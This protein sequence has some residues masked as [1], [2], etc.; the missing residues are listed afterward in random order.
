M[1]RILDYVNPKGPLPDVAG[2]KS[3]DLLIMGSAACLWDDLSRYDHL[4]Y[5]DRMAV[6]YALVHYMERLDHGVTLHADFM[7]G[8][9]FKQFFLGAH[10]GWPVIQT[11]AH[12]PNHA[13]KHVWPLTRDGG[14]SG[15]FGVLIG[16][17]LGYERI[18]LAGSPVDDSP[19]FYYPYSHPD[20]SY[21]R[22]VIHDEWQRAIQGC[23]G[24]KVKSLSGNTKIWLGGPE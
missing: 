14:T 17:L 9:A 1:K 18:I 19:S 3:G 22:Q 2:T 5:G 21:G 8:L 13:V 20:V 12:M 16:L 10:K 24:G 7:Y 11:H 4:H 6:N 15:L 23:F